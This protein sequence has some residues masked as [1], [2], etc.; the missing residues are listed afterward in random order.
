MR[1][2]ASVVSPE[3]VTCTLLLWLSPFY[4][5]SRHLQWLS[6]PVVG[7]AQS[8]W[9]QWASLWLPS[10][11][12][13]S[14]QAFARAAVAPNCRVLSLCHPLSSFCWWVGPAVRPG[15][16]L[17][18]TSGATVELVC[19]VFFLSSQGRSHFGVVLTPI[20]AACTLLVYPRHFFQTGAFILYLSRTFCCAISW[21]VGTQFP[22][23]L[24]DLLE[25]SPLIFKV[26]DIK[27]LDC[28]NSN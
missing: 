26:L 24:L 27:L 17:H 6:L 16:S 21:R 25:H 22:I 7:T 14:N 11:S 4:L 1:T 2:G 5:L 23:L 18:S 8:L 28:K 12:V 3:Y 10:A 19:V 13:G 20:V 15:V 9:C